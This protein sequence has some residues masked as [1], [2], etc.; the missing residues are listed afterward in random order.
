MRPSTEPARM[1]TVIAANTNWKKTSVAIGKASSGMPE[2][3]AGMVAWPVVNAAEVAE[4][5]RAEEREPL[6]SERHVVVEENP[7]DQNR[8]EGIHRHEGG[9]DRPFLLD[10]AAIQNHEARNALQPD[11]SC[12]RQL[13]GIVSGI[14]PFG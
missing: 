8:G 9:V 12:R 1:M 14:E 6:R 4:H 7:D 11:E 13:P 3:A 5:R 10:D 2:A